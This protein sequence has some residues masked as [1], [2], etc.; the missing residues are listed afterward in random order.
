[1][2]CLIFSKL[3]FRGHAQA[4]IEVLMERI[5]A[6]WNA[7]KA[8]PFKKK[9][10]HIWLYYKWAIIV[11][12]AV[13]CILVSIAGT[14]ANNRRETLI[15]GIFI[16]NSTSQQGYSHLMEG[17]W[18]Y[19]GGNDAQKVE[20]IAGRNIDFDAQTLSQEDAAAFMIVA[21]MIAAES[22]DYIITDEASLDDFVEQEVVLDLREL[23]PEDPLSRWETVELGGIVAGLRL[24]NTAFGKGYPLSGENSVILITANAQNKENVLFFL[25]Y[26]LEEA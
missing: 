15:S 13:I 10:E 26:L 2:C 22:L 3:V 18:Q 11:T 24:E 17:Y 8:L 20:L 23:L 25:D 1:M 21:S 4:I 9:L 12:A 14:V 6:E 16:N 7:F 5:R 19:C